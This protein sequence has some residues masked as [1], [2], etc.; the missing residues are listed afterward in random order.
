MKDFVVMRQGVDGK[1]AWQMYIGFRQSSFVN[2]GLISCFGCALVQIDEK[3]EW[4]NYLFDHSPDWNIVTNLVLSPVKEPRVNSDDLDDVGT[5]IINN[6]RDFI[7][8]GN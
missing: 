6:I 7:A 1:K 2:D 8:R 4:F 5:Q 3:Q